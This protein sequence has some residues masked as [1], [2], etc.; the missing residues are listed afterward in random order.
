MGYLDG[1]YNDDEDDDLMYNKSL[2]KV[3]WLILMAYQLNWDYFMPR[4]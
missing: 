3:D 1:D 2:I 4:D